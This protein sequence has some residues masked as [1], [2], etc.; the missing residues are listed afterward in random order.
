MSL[1]LRQYTQDFCF[2]I[3]GH[4]FASRR[5]ITEFWY[6]KL[7]MLFPETVKTAVTSVFHRVTQLLLRSA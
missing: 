7:W 4:F 3:F 1:P 5:H 2:G 6:F